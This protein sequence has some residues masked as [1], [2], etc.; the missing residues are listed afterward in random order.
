PR[1]RQVLFCLYDLE[2]FRG[3][4][5]YEIL[6]THPKVLIGSTV[7]ENLYYVPPDEFVAGQR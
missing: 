7:L 3:D 6:K 1:H 5:L 4:L 2:Q